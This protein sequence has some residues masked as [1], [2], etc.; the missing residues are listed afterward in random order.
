MGPPF[1]PHGKGD[2]YPCARGATGALHTL[3]Q[4]DKLSN[5]EWGERRG[6][7]VLSRLSLH[8]RTPGSPAEHHPSYCPCASHTR[9][10][11]PTLSPGTPGGPASP[12]APLTPSLP[13]SPGSPCQGRAQWSEGTVLYQEYTVLVLCALG[14]GGEEWSQ[15]EAQAEKDMAGL[16][17]AP[18]GEW[19][20]QRGCRRKEPSST[21]EPGASSATARDHNATQ[22]RVPVAKTVLSLSW[23]VKAEHPKCWVLPQDPCGAGEPGA[24]ARSTPFP[25]ETSALQGLLP[26][27][28]MSVSPCAPSS[29]CL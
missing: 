2:T 7:W 27:Q 16:N 15:N 14:V 12:R 3:Q 9:H 22:P 17:A 10:P 5:G 29:V 19:E 20:P 25:L 18:S 21:A 11:A 8:T 4:R 28:G 23:V 26:S 1:R 13:G 24:R 6:S